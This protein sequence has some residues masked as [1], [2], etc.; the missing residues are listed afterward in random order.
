M[1]ETLNSIL[2]IQELDM[3]M[4]RLM[5]VKQERQK[6]LANIYNLRNDL[7]KQLD[8]KEQEI[9][10]IKKNVRLSET[11]IAE[12]EEKVKSLEGHQESV[13]KV[14]EFNALSHEIAA[15]GRQRMHK[16]HQRDELLEKLIEEEESLKSL[17]SHAKESEESSKTYEEELLGNIKHINEEG[18]VIKKDRDALKV[19]VDQEVLAIYERLF[20]NKKDRV[21]VPIENRTCS[22]CHI[23]ITAQHENL[24]RKC[25]RLVFC[26]HC[27]RIHYWQ[28]SAAIEESVVATKK[29]RRKTTTTKK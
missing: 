17:Q 20:F 21:V 12:A 5:R 16:E 11:A 19:G 18:T 22:G 8:V 23:V 28:E 13:K 14:D 27:S 1:L 15:A 4:I 6:E 10:E 3:K 24:V 26:E 25:E 9:L 7:H 2:Q 29:R